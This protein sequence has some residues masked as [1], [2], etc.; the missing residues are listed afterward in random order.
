M[1]FA[2][3]PMTLARAVTVGTVLGYTVIYTSEY[4]RKLAVTPFKNSAKNPR[5][6]R[7]KPPSF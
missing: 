4:T 2:F 5:S 6:P 3:V 1:H 7:G